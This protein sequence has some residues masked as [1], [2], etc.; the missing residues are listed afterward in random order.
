MQESRGALE[1]AGD[2][3]ASTVSRDGVLRAVPFRSRVR[4][5]SVAMLLRRPIFTEQP[6]ARRGQV[7][8]RAPARGK[9]GDSL[10]R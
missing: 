4:A 9:P 7:S 3:E 8:A 5:G 10:S 2:D 1:G 6:I